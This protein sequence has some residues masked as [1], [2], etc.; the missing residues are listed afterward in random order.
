MTKILTPLQH[1]VL[2]AFFAEPELKRHFYLTGGTAL[3]AFYL[4]HRLS[5]DLD[6]FTHS[7]DLHDVERLIEGTFR[8]NKFKFEKERSSPTYRRWLIDGEL[9]IDV[10]RDIDFR[11][12]TPQL[13]G[14]FMVDDPKNIAVNKVTTIYSRLDAKDYVDLY[15]LKPYLNYDIME[16]F[17]LAEMK[18]GGM[19]PF[20]WCKIIPDVDTF[21][22]LP[23]MVKPLTIK[24]LQ[25]FFHR[26]RDDILDRIKPS[27]ENSDISG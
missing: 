8:A 7:V 10:V 13:I 1:K 23:Q 2:Q 11:V 4:K 5:I 18:D 21:K 24:E 15:F 27:P 9:Q 26:L 20:Q 12:G 6:F 14:D 19:D 22:I 3:S 25:K 17:K 16:L